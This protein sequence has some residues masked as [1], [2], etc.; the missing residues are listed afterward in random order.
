MECSQDK[1]V[2]KGLLEG[3]IAEQMPQLHAQRRQFEAEN[4]SCAIAAYK[5]ISPVGSFLLVT[6]SVI[7]FLC[8]SAAQAHLRLGSAPRAKTVATSIQSYQFGQTLP[9]G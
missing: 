3:F 6:H 9:S 1:S 5:A 7:N 4:C 8:I 2:D